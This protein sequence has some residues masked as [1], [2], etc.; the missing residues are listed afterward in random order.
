LAKS[1]KLDN[2]VDSPLIVFGIVSSENILKLSW[3][4]N[5]LLNIR[6]SQ[7]AGLQFN[8]TK[9]N[10]PVEFSLFQYEVENAHLKYSLIENRIKGTYCFNEFRNIDFLLFVRGETDIKLKDWILQTLRKSAEITSILLIGS[11]KFKLKKSIEH[12]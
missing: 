3:V 2:P 5:Q 11:E 12:F 6:L 10:H 9:T 7:S 4:I 8:E 1:I